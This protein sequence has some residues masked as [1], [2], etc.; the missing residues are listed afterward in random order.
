MDIVIKCFLLAMAAVIVF[1]VLT[2]AEKSFGLVLIL[3]V[4]S[5][6]LICAMHFIH[7]VLDFLDRLQQNSGIDSSVLIILL[8]ITG[9]GLIAEIATLIC[10]DAGNAS[11]GKAIGIL[12]SAAVLWMALPVMQELLDLITQILDT[13]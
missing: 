6:V 8:K 11:M 4:S 12:T 10:T 7:P 2:H 5:C 9:L 3:F 1:P 13:L